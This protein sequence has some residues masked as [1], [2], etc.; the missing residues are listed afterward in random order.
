MPELHAGYRRE[1]IGDNLQTTS[2]FTGG[3]GA[4]SG[5]SPN[6]AQNK[7][8]LGAQLKYYSTEN[9]ELT[10]SYD[11]DVKQD[12]AAHAGFLRAGWKF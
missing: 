3:G 12:Y 4:F 2:T 8:N 11:F 5:Q 7:F 9:I 10:A 6:P 1:V